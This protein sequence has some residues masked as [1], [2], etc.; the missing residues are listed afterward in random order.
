[1]QPKIIAEISG[2]HNGDLK[3][4]LDSI[5]AAHAA[6]ADMIKI[7]TYEPS[8]LTIQS[9]NDYFLIDSG[10]IWDKEN[11]YSLYQ[12][13]HTPFTW[14]KDLFNHAKKI[15]ATL[16]SSPFSLRG[17]ELLESLDCPMYKIASF[18]II[19]LELIKAVASTKKPIIISTG[20]AYKNEIQ[21]ALN[22]ANQAS[23]ITLLLCT[24][25]YPAPLES[26]NL[27][28]LNE[29]KKYGVKV[30]LSDHTIGSLCPILATALGASIIE[31]HFILDRSLGGVDSSFSMQKDEFEQMC[32]DVKNAYLALGKQENKFLDSSDDSFYTCMDKSSNRAFARSIFVIKDI[33]QGEELSEE[34]IKVIRPGFGLHPKFFDQI[35]G[36]KATKFLK[37]ATP[38]TKEDFS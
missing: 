12:K 28:A 18:E 25:S 7:Q 26:M 22:A 19:D 1:M 11:L 14:H 33:K 24:S 32:K 4:A 9:N 2:N 17:L 29:L 3:L 5:S 15:G 37:K 6:G 36:K 16:F 21:E 8:C 10:T 23:D 13:A 38:L 34:N 20:I 27:L 35:L 31:K 30:G